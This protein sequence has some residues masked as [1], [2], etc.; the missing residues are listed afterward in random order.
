MEFKL[1]PIEPSSFYSDHITIVVALLSFPSIRWLMKT[2]H[3][4]VFIPKDPQ[5]QHRKTIVAHYIGNDHC[6][7]RKG[8][9]AHRKIPT[10]IV[11][12]YM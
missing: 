3:I 11:V 8:T 1:E 6:F 9:D 12:G 7:L 4:Y 5:L 10:G 2:I